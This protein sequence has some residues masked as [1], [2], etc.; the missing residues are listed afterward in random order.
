MQHFKIIVFSFAFLLMSKNVQAKRF[1]AKVIKQRGIVSILPPRQVNAHRIKL[2]EKLEEDSSILTGANSFVRIEFSDKS[3]VS[4]GPQSKFVIIE[5][6]EKEQ[7]VLGLFKGKIRS[8]VTKKSQNKFFIK[9]PSAAVGVRGTDFH[10]VYNPENKVTTTLTYKGDVEM[11]KVKKNLQL[12]SK[13]IGKTK[14]KDQGKALKKYFKKMKRETSRVLEGQVASVVTVLKRPT[15]PVKLNVVQANVLYANKDM[16]EKVESKKDAIGVEKM[17]MDNVIVK[18]KKQRAPAEGFFDEKTEEFAP[19]NGGMVDMETG[20]YIPPKNNSSLDKKSQMFMASNIGDVDKKTG[21][22]INPEGTKLDATAGMIILAQNDANKDLESMKEKIYSK[23]LVKKKIKRSLAEKMA[24]K[25]KEAPKNYT[26]QSYTYLDLVKKNEIIFS[27]FKFD[28]ELEFENSSASLKDQVSESFEDGF[29]LKW[30][31]D[32]DRTKFRPFFAFGVKD[33]EY[34]RAKGRG[35]SQTV[36]TL[37][38]LNFGTHYYIK[39]HYYLLGEIGVFQNFYFDRRSTE[40]TSSLIRVSSTDI[41]LGFGGSFLRSRYGS[42]HFEFAPFLSMPK[43]T[44]TFR[45][46]LGR[47]LSGEINYRRWFKKNIWGSIGPWFY[48][49]S[50]DI[51]GTADTAD[52][53]R[54]ETGLKITYGQTF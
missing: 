17:K 49:E 53:H 23:D 27:Y 40:T 7:T 5:S 41:K 1:I 21:E 32:N 42:V 35:I 11:L 50:S 39:R 24:K 26:A 54:T 19:R 33:I 3:T 52:H 9:T 12:S 47:G 22:Y 16:V 14:S 28:Q 43:T 6:K 20:L 38:H 25:R 2:G 10:V 30:I 46:E 31:F 13:D 45:T 44:G 29:D 15:M 4:L 37:Y 18:A 34:K 36:T 51:L 8:E 48:D